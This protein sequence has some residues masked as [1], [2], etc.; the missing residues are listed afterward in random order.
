MALRTTKSSVTFA[1]PFKLPELDEAQPAGTYDVVT[2][3]EMIEGNERTV[4]I[5]VS[6]SLYVKHGGT[7][8]VVTVDP[9]GLQ[10]ALD[11][12]KDA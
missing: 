1:A 10:A 12:D 6:T 8:S 11:R 9:K 7:T 2:D 5:R 4:Y 3:E